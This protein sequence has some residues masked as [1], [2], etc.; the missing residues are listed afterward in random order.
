MNPPGD[1]EGAVRGREPRGYLPGPKGS[2]LV[3][4]PATRPDGTPAYWVRKGAARE[5]ELRMRIG[6]EGRDPVW[7]AW[8]LDYHRPLPKDATITWATVHRRVRG[9]HSEWSLCV[10]FNEPSICVDP[11]DERPIVAVDVGWRVVGEELRIAVWRNSAGEC[12]ELRLTR[13]DLSALRQSEGIRAARDGAFDRCHAAAVRWASTSTN[14]PEWM[15]EWLRRT[16]SAG[17]M[18]SLLRRW[19]VERP[20]RADD[21]ELAYRAIE[22]W[23]FADRHRWAEETARRTWGLR[24]RRDKYRVFAADLAKRHRVIV[25]ERFDLRQ[26]AVRAETGEDKAENETARGNRQAASVS[27]LRT[28]ILNAAVRRASVVASVESA[29]STRTHA[30]C[31][32]VADRDAGA[33]TMLLCD[34]CQESFDQDDNAARVLLTRYCEHP[35][36]AEIIGG[37][38]TPE[39]EAE[40]EGKKNSRWT[41][42]KRLGDAKRVRLA[43]AREAG[44]NVVK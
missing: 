35:G 3:R 41:K 16:E 37:A 7:A 33:S 40:S 18:V 4:A 10:T 6:S 14:V 28:V 25:L 26:V 5:G 38:R 9:P 43:T 34:A 27:E 32:V 44:G 21:E 15:G 29:D 30:A 23:A 42:A 39:M 11:A 24:R 31:G 36:D 1:G 12:G 22:V 20:E 8:R 2:P 19:A 13:Q 17:R